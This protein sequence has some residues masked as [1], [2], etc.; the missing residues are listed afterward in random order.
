VINVI[1]VKVM[2]YS[3]E[4]TLLVWLD[5]PAILDMVKKVCTSLKLRI[6]NAEVYADAYA[7][8]YFFEV[9]TEDPY[10]V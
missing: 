4:S 10:L 6:F 5:N 8:P 3:Y 7:I 1:K 9:K 2:N